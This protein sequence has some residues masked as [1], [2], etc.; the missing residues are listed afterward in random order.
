MPTTDKTKLERALDF[1]AKH[2]ELSELFGEIS[3]LPIDDWP[4]VHVQDAEGN[5]KWRP[6]LEVLSS[7]TVLMK[8][9]G[10]PYTMKGKPGRR[11]SAKV[12][13]EA[14]ARIKRRKE[15]LANDTLYAIAKDNPDDPMILQAMIVAITKEAAI[16]SHDRVEAEREGVS[17]KDVATISSR[18]LNALARANDLWVKRRELANTG[19][20]DLNSPEFAGVFEFIVET[21]NDVLESSGFRGEQIDSVMQ[22]FSAAVGDSEWRVEAKQRIAH[23]VEV[24]SNG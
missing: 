21:F 17:A 1:V 19:M 18:R 22:K 8:A 23:A 16:L 14:Q 11:T 15:I 13:P 6:I 10:K 7:D 2:K 12:D 20:L 5:R 9:N 4:R 3:H 24:A